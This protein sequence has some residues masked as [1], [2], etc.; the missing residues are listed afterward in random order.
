VEETVTPIEEQIL[1]DLIEIIVTL[2]RMCPAEH[3]GRL[4]NAIIASERLLTAEVQAEVRRR[5]QTPPRCEWAIALCRT[6]ASWCRPAAPF[7]D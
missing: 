6:L 5:A 7:S 1:C 4:A 3:Q 2:N